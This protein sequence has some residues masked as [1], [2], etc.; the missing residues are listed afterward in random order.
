MTGWPVPFWGTKGPGFK[1][2]QPDREIA[3]QMVHGHPHRR[4]Y[5]RGC[6]SVLVIRRVRIQVEG[7]RHR[8]VPESLL[9]HPR[10]HRAQGPALRACGASHAATGSRSSFDPGLLKCVTRWVRRQFLHEQPRERSGPAGGPRTG[11]RAAGPSDPP[12]PCRP[13]GDGAAAPPL[14][15]PPTWE[16][17]RGCF[18][19]TSVPTRTGCDPTV[20]PRR[21]SDRSH[22]HGF[23]THRPSLRYKPWRLREPMAVV[24]SSGPWEAMA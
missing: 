15:R 20:C 9:H 12:C 1:S 6:V 7:D 11:E 18:C 8:R 17:G 21:R 13:C 3:G 16:K 2:R 4:R 24:V 23:L 14:V 19:T 22:A 5:L 10:R